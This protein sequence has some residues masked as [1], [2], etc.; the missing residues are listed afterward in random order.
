MILRGTRIAA[1]ALATA[2]L[3]PW[4]AA[5]DLLAEAESAAL[6]AEKRLAEVEKIGGGADETPP[7]RAARKFE[8]GEAQYLLGDWL[9]AAILLSDAVDEP[10][11]RDARQHPEALFLLA[12]AL[13]RQG[14]CGA[15][16]ARYAELLSLGASERRGAAITGALDCA[17]KEHR[18]AEIEVLLAEAGK[19]FGDDAPPEVRYLAAK[20]LFQRADLPPRERAERAAAAFEK[21]GRPFQLQAR[22]F[23]GVLAI[24]QGNLHGSLQWF[25][26][27]ARGDPEGARQ[28]EVREMCLL[29][30]GRVHAEMGNTSASLD[31]YAAI[32]WESPRFAEALYELAWTFVKGQKYDQALRTASFIADLA[33]DSPLAPEAI[34]L[35]GHLLLRLGRYTEATDA[36]N[37]VINTYAPVRDELDA[38]LAM[39]ADPVRYFNE[40]IGRQGKAFDVASVLPAVAV[41]WASTKQEVD[42]ALDLVAALDRARREVQASREVAGRME[43]LL[44]RGGG[45]DAFP[46]LRRAYA[47]AEAIENDAALLEGMAVSAASAAAE[48]ALPAGGR[49]DVE[50]ARAARLALEPLARALPRTQHAVDERVLRMRSRIDRVD[51]AAFQVGYLVDSLGASVTGT[52]IWIEQHRAEIDSDPEGRQQ[53]AEELRQHRDV[54]SAYEGELG[55]LRGEVARVRDAAAGT[56]ALSEEARVRSE[57]LAAV[58]AERGAAAAARASLPGPD[59]ETFARADAL[60]E[61]LAGLRAR[62]EATRLGFAADASR[63]AGELRDRVAAEQASLSGHAGAL[64]GVQA[65]AKDLVGRIAYRSFV[66]VRSQFYKLVLKADVGIVDVAWSRKRQRLDKIQQLSI[67]KAS[68]IEQ[69]DREYRAMLREVD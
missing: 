43:A 7:L 36:Y 60:H 3:A 21:V 29:A 6:A 35:E 16:R 18:T 44:A 10:A 27:C 1:A 55:A 51:R 23:Q 19:T 12:D 62:A 47:S 9:H 56:D 63:R 2:A 66:D 53:L 52:E 22:Y 30:L 5:A 14:A 15:A 26:S 37:H 68:E 32:P 67:Q 13:R 24:Q 49:Q 50:R 31:W 41:K 20:A 11:F 25:E 34:V 33:P 38:I 4:S 58:E 46:G 40:L 64:D 28:A 69:L 54:V 48:K 39:R 65:A 17:V 42:V 61:R 57:Y 8:Q 45:L 59:R